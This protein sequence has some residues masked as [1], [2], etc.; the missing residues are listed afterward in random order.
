VERHLLSIVFVTPLVG[1]LV[2]LAVGRGRSRVSWAIAAATTAMALAASLPLWFGFAVRGA[3]WQF[4][5]QLALMPSLGASYAVGIDGVSLLLILLTTFLTFIVVIAP[6]AAVSGRVTEYFV[7]V[8]LLEAGML[9]VYMSLD[10]LLFCLCWLLAAA[11]MAFLIVLAGG[12]TRTGLREWAIA[13]VPGL[14]ILLGTVALSAAAQ[15][16]TGTRTFDLRMLQ[17]LALP[18]TAQRWVFLAFF[19][20][21]GAGL[22]AV[23]RLWLTVAGDGRAV[24]VPVLLA[25]VFLK[26][27]TYGFLRLS[28]PLLPEA[29]RA[30]APAIVALS[31]IGIVYGGVAAFAQ[32]NWTRVLAYASLSHF[33]LVTLGAFA[34]TPDGLTGSAVHE[35]N[36]G[37][38]IAA[39]FLVAGLVAERGRETALAEYG[40]LFNAMPLAAGIWMLMTLSLVGVPR[41]N[42]FVGT[43]LIVEGI[44]PVSKVWATV[45]ISGMILSGVGLFWVFSRTMLGELRSPATGVLKDLRLR[46]AVVFAPLVAAAMWVGISPAP[47]LAKVETSVAR[48]VLRVSPQYAPEVAGCLSQPVPP[49]ADTGLPAGMVIAA[50]CA[51]GTASPQSAPRESPR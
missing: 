35:I 19:V 1:A 7:A 6:W 32:T 24:A 48:V 38:S 3:Q 10:L 11:A 31:A 40:G 27:G 47:L 21:F 2:L 17:D 25:A 46:E 44:W 14:V 13:I 16:L 34:L 39:L 37:V 36:H 33:C 20:G 8:L 9:G 51:D 49:P 41:L 4:T 50:P 28:L 43:R 26:M 29:S 45:A 23:F 15:S 12:G 30:F 42:G 22:L 5:E 18:L